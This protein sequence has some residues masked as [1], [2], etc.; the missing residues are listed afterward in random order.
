MTTLTEDRMGMVHGAL[1]WRSIWPRGVSC[2]LLSGLVFGLA[3][4][5]NFV[6]A[7]SIYMVTPVSCLFDFAR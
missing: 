7:A 4:T 3:V 5:G 1:R 2:G 6:A